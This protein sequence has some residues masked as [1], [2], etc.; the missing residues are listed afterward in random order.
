MNN[1]DKKKKKI[2]LV[3]LWVDDN[4]PKWQEKKSLWQQKLNIIDNIENS[5][6]KCRFRNNI[7]FDP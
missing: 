2:D 4:D 7:H 1:F 6:S 3:Y 5:T